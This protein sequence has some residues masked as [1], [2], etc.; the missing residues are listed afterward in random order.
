MAS[1][2]VAHIGKITRSQIIINIMFS[3]SMLQYAFS[4]QYRSTRRTSNYLFTFTINKLQLQA[5]CKIAELIEADSMQESCLRNAVPIK[6]KIC[7]PIA[8]Q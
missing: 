3:E 7:G 4:T 1:S 5:T 6:W 8:S 2:K